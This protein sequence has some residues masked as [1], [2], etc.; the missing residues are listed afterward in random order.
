LIF[1]KKYVIIYII[2]K[3]RSEK[4]DSRNTNAGYVCGYEGKRQ[5]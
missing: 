4:N 5:I 1:Y 3:E 2:N